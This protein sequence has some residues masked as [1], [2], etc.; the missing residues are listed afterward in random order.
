MVFPK[1]LLGIKDL[2]A[3]Q[4]NEILKTAKIMREIIDNNNKKTPTIQFSRS[5]LSL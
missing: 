5:F 2:N 4:I 3:D 1:D